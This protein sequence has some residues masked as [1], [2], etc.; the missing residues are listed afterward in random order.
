MR[1]GLFWSGRYGLRHETDGGA[2]VCTC[3]VSG[4][5]ETVVSAM[6]FC[7]VNFACLIVAAFVWSIGE[8]DSPLCGCCVV[9]CGRESGR[10]ERRQE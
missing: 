10:T 6:P 3:G 2:S 7:G 5:S 4:R 9:G 1:C 8:H